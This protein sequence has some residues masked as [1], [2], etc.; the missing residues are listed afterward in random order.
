MAKWKIPLFKMHCEEKDIL[1]VEKVLRRKE[2]WAAGPEV[3]EFEEKLAKFNGTKYALTFN[4]G[5]SALHAMF[6]AA[7]LK[8]KEVIVPSF[9]FIATANALVLA[10]AI[11]VFAEIEKDTYALDA[12][13]VKNIKPE[14]I[15]D[16]ARTK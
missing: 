3:E 9:T 6:L 14:G 2:S 10:G 13:D 4:S 1:A 5:T 7:G 12:E 16:G 8:G 11:P 15:Q